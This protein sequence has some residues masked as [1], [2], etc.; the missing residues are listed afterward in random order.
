[1]NMFSLKVYRIITIMTI[2]LLSFSYG[3]DLKIV[4]MDGVFDLDNDDLVE[5]ITIEEG[6]GD[7]GVTGK[8]GYYEIDELGYP[9]LLWHLSSR[10][11]PFMPGAGA[12][13]QITGALVDAA[14]TDLNGSG[15]AELVVAANVF[16]PNEMETGT[17]LVFQWTQGEFPD[18]PTLTL[19]LGDPTNPQTVNNLI[20]LDLEGDGMDELAVGLQ[21]QQS[22]ISVFGLKTEENTSY[23]REV[24]NNPLNEFRRT[25]AGTFDYNR[26]GQS[27]L[28]A[29]SPDG[30]ILRLQAF[31][32]QGGQLT[33]ASSILHRVTGMSEALYRSMVTLDWDGDSRDDLLVPFRS[34][35]VVKL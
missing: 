14:I 33:P 32:N 20:L 27:D 2:A 19:S 7:G 3:A 8:V 12:R 9:Q 25:Y 10:S 30:N 1:M 5:F 4:H 13:F 21:G 11:T 23:L 34:G 35:H 28:I 16:S 31:L 29:F 26:D 24:W 22:T 6:K 17:I 18:Q 15:T